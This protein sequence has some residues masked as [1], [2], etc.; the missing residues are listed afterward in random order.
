[1]NC[2]SCNTKLSWVGPKRLKQDGSQEDMCFTC[3]RVSIL[4]AHDQD[5]LIFERDYHHSSITEVFG[6]SV[7][8]SDESNDDY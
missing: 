5:H 1:M 6:I 4:A 8:M 7:D 2:V 3:L